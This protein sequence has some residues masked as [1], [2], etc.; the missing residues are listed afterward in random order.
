MK[1][2]TFGKVSFVVGVLFLEGLTRGEGLVGVVGDGEVGF[3]LD[4]DGVGSIVLV[5]GARA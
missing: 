1:A 3:P 2:L 5:I 4:F